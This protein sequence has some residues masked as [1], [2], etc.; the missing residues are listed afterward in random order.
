MKPPPPPALLLADF[1][2][3]M[4]T[5]R[6]APA[7][8]T[9][10]ADLLALARRV[11]D[12][13]KHKY[14]AHVHLRPGDCE[15]SG[16]AIPQ[17]WDEGWYFESF[18]NSLGGD[19]EEGVLTVWVHFEAWTFSERVAR[20]RRK[21][22]IEDEEGKERMEVDG[23][24]GRGDECAE[25][26]RWWEAVGWWRM[27]EGVERRAR[28]KA[29]PKVEE[30]KS[31][32]TVACPRAKRKGL[33]GFVK[34]EVLGIVREELSDAI[35]VNLSERL[36]KC[37]EDMVEEK[38]R[39]AL[40]EE[41]LDPA[42]PR[43][44]RRRMTYEPNDVNELHPDKPIDYSNFPWPITH[45]L[46]IPTTPSTLQDV[47]TVD[48]YATSKQYSRDLIVGRALPSICV[49]PS[50]RPL[51][52]AALVAQNNSSTSTRVYTY[53]PSKYGKKPDR[54]GELQIPLDAV[55]Y[56]A[57]FSGAHSKLE[58]SA[59][60]AAVLKQRADAEGETASFT[61]LKQRPHTRDETFTTV[62]TYTGTSFLDWDIIIGHAEAEICADPG[63]RPLVRASLASQDRV[64]SW[65]PARHSNDRT[66]TNGELIISLANVR[67]WAEFD[68]P[69]EMK[70][71]EK[72][73]AAL[74]KKSQAW[75]GHR[76]QEATVVG[77]DR[78]VLVDVSDEGN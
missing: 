15:A 72:I 51:V 76:S 35:S 74:M 47:I 29:E 69:T 10:Y 68:A 21:L 17:E 32:D 49:D 75:Q 31:D 4:R 27:A 37:I 53:I 25:G 64:H 50:I 78:A 34:D 23:L 48:A 8:A 13:P 55:E 7:R 52:R 43:R 30:R 61:T 11:F 57:P 70:R 6:I 14:H 60:I 22:G 44:K 19:E 41:R 24:V 28:E 42:R 45:P 1:T 46:Q 16:R 77:D 20:A 3:P 58:R 73:R 66:R 63:L 59:K 9:H 2:A 54:I 12:R 62:D 67:V 56:I 33:P 71:R 40:D 39:K 18:G 26:G 38:V 36:R 5:Y 65:I